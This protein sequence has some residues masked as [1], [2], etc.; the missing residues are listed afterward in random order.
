M[1]YSLQVHGAKYIFPI[2]DGLKELSSDIIREVL[3]H[4]PEHING[5]IADYLETM[6]EVREK[7]RGRKIYVSLSLSVYHYY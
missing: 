6:L 1:D 7:T 3:R 2:P 5:F 4:Q